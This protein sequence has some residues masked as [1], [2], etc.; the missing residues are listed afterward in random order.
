MSGTGY[1][2]YESRYFAESLR[3]RCKSINA[4]SFSTMPHF[5]TVMCVRLL[6]KPVFS[7]VLSQN[8]PRLV[9]FIATGIKSKVFL[10]MG[11]RLGA[12]VEAEIR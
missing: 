1:H 3:R 2:G 6:V 12:T 7:L 4:P 10:Q 11:H 8:L 9:G 5:T